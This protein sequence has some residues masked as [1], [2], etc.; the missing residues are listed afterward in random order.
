MAFGSEQI[1]VYNPKGTWQFAM[2]ETSFE[3]NQP[4]TEAVLN[5]PLNG[6]KFPCKAQDSVLPEAYEDDDRNCV[7]R[8]LAALFEE[9][10][11]VIAFELSELF[12]HL[13]E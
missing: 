8:Q 13:P 5:R 3:G 2:M 11:D 7:I 9:P 4:R 1:I 6:W 10:Y 12:R